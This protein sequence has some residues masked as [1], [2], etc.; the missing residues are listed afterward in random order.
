MSNQHALEKEYGKLSA[1]FHQRSL[2]E[3]LLILICG[4]VVLILLMYTLLFEP[5]IDS[6]HKLKQNTQ[7]NQK[8]L[9]TMQSQMALLTDKLQNDPNAA[10]TKRIEVLNDEIHNITIQ[11]E[12]QTDNLIPANK[13]AA[14]LENVLAGSKGL[15]L[16]ELQSIDPVP[17]ILEP[18]EESGAELYRHGVTMLF[19]GKYFDIQQYLEELESLPWKFYWKKFDYVVGD[20]PSA[21]VELEIYTLS[22]NKAF[23]GV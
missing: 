7:N 9:N 4:L 6:S 18:E 15:R 2:R 8:E 12:T 20:Y 5:L 11:L 17:I 21:S 22:S 16:I 13:M 23:I 1:K 19:E 3:K 14:M 10:I